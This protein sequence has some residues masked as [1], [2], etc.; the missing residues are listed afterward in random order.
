MPNGNLYGFSGWTYL[1]ERAH[2]WAIVGQGY[3]VKSHLTAGDNVSFMYTKGSSQQQSTSLG[4]GIS[5]YGL[6][7]GYD[8]SGTHSSTAKRSNG[9]PAQTES[10]FFRT[11]FFPGQF[12]GECYWLPYRQVP[13]VPQAKGSKCPTRY[14]QAYVHM[15]L[16]MVQSVGWVAGGDEVHPT[17]PAPGV[18]D[19]SKNC[20][21]Y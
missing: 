15:C 8:S 3:I 1:D 7:A 18:K 5:G 17:G 13:R 12:R 19:P 20:S 16:W 2:T 14:Q 10:S 21:P 9:Y 11:M 4:V 6:N